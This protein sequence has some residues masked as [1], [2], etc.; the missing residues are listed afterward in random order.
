MK[1]WTTYGLLLLV[2]LLAS[3]G[4]IW[5]L[6]RGGQD[7]NVFY[8]A[9]THVLNG[10]GFEIYTHSPD[11]FL[12]APGFAWI[13]SPLAVL[14][15]T[16]ALSI[17]CLM[18][19]AALGFLIQLLYKKMG[20]REERLQQKALRVT[21][22]GLLFWSK[23]ILIDFQYGQVNLFI[24][25]ICVWALF[26]YFNPSQ[27]YATKVKR[28]IAWF[29]L[30]IVSFGKIFPAPLLILPWLRRSRSRQDKVWIER[31]SSL[32]GILLILMIPFLSLGFDGGR[33][34]LAQWALALKSKGLPLE[35]HNQSFVAFVHHAF[36]GELIFPRANGQEGFYIRFFTLSKELLAGLGIIWT[37]LAGGFLFYW[38]FQEKKQ[39]TL[40]WISVL[41]GGLIIP[42]HLIWKTYFV[43]GIP[44]VCVWLWRESERW[45]V[46]AILAIVVNFTGFDFIGYELAGRLEALASLFW[47]HLYVLLSLL[48][49]WRLSPFQ[50]L[51]RKISSIFQLFPSL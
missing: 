21:C 3:L 24:L 34:L 50:K 15:Q 42:S 43:M 19:A 36:S 28:G 10:R 2:G 35:S 39:P 22:L 47:I 45:L 29:L 26:L 44:A 16:F 17:W 38:F 31:G 49:F 23:P 27:S 12:Y 7:F 9:W 46:P 14:P 6:Q 4:T 8:T 11:R 32:L 33:D 18:K 37:F 51:K 20:S 13:L 25:T 41:I 48:G 5:S 40:L 1:A 30:G